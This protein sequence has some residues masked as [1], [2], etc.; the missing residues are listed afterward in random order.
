MRGV[1]RVVVDV[2][3][4]HLD[5]RLNGGRKSDVDRENGMDQYT[6]ARQK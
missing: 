4:Q 6:K 5:N 1:E 3:G 2:G